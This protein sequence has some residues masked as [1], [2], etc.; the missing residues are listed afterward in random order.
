MC[1]ASD[2]EWTTSGTGSGTDDGFGDTVTVTAADFRVDASH[3]AY[4]GVDWREIHPQTTGLMNAS[5]LAAGLGPVID[6]TAVEELGPL[7]EAI[8]LHDASNPYR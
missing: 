3:T 4:A 8:F 6:W 2:D 7:G 1:V 5:L